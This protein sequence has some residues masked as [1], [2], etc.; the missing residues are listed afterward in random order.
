MEASLL[1]LSKFTIKSQLLGIVLGLLAG[2]SAL[3]LFAISQIKVI[4]DAAQEIQTNWLPSVR[5]TGALKSATNQYAG[6]IP[7]HILNTD[8]NAMAEIEKGIEVVLAQAE[9]ARGNYE[10]LISSPEERKLYDEF[11]HNWTG[12]LRE[13]QTV[14]EHSRKNDNNVARDL[15]S[16]KA[17]PLLNATNS[18]LDKLVDLSNRGAA[19]ASQIAADS[20]NSGL[21]WV[22]VFLVAAIAFGLW[23]AIMVIH[24]ITSGIASIN[25]P[26]QQ[27]AAGDL[28]VGIPSLPERTELGQ[29]ANT[30]R[31]FKKNL[32]A[33]KASSAAAALDA[34]AKIEHAERLAMLTDNFE[35][36]VGSI[37]GIVAA[38]SAE[39]STTAEQLTK[40]A[41]G[42]S[43]RSIAVAAASE[44][45]SANVQTVASAAE[46]LSCSVREIAG[47]VHRSSTMT[48]KA[49]NEAEQ[50][51]E[52][53]RELARAAERIGGI[54]DLIN[55]IASQTNLLA[56]NATIE[57]ARAGE[58]GRGFAV[59]AQEVKALAEQTAKATAE[60]GDQITG[61][62]SST[63]Q[64]IDR[65]EAIA[66]TI[67]EVDSIAGSIASSVAEQGSATQE[68]AR[69]VHHASQGTAEVAENI[70]GVQ[71]A[72]E[73]TSAAASQV[74]SSARDLSQQSES[75]LG[76]VN[77]FLY[78]VRAA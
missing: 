67:G 36:T 8:D 1:A 18:T 14:L 60:I 65:I 35:Q 17:L 58:A 45:A 52:Q 75:M 2:L 49:S 53:V 63:Q 38:A 23:A 59:V 15:N 40:T 43:E 71:E 56:L 69:N 78:D 6:G 66:R 46:E 10:P 72:A 25:T 33:R 9:K 4:N 7:I 64:A 57:A 73:G 51:S 16:Q 74:F 24:N 3:G 48:S 34:R 68:I 27:L 62:Q 37:V 30:L 42:T 5:W 19:D 39:L 26:M 50:T 20:Y 31:V 77:K 28:A 70:V 44:Q 29:M 76:V 61:I 11:A 41:K 22:I 13:V 32:I 21:L 55:N 12:Y 47:Q 54:I